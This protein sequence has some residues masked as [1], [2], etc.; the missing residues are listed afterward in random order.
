M[1]ATCILLLL[2]L[3]VDDDSVVAAS[4]DFLLSLFV[5]PI[6]NIVVVVVVVN[7]SNIGSINN[8]KTILMRCVLLR[9]D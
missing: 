4:I 9:N 1:C 8:N 5:W 6:S 2:L 3:C 7:F